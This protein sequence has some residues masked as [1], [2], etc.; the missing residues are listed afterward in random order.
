MTPLNLPAETLN[1]LGA[2]RQ[3]KYDFSRAKPG[4]VSLKT[5]EALKQEA[6]WVGTDIPTDPH[7]G[8]AGY[9]T[10]PAISLTGKRDT[11]DGEFILLW[12]P[13]ERLF[14]TWDRNRWLLKVFVN[15]SWRDIVVNPVPF[16]NALW[17]PNDRRGVRFIPW[18]EYEFKPGRPA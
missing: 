9:Y 2:G 7:H 15:V 11:R 14:G 6:I 13:L 3:L 5:L 4:E 1:F 10:I 8:E 18:P 17:D 16:L 12:L